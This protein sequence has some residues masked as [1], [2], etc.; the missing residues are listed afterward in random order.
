VNIL[1]RLFGLAAGLALLAA[2][3][4]TVSVASASESQPVSGVWQLTS[5]ISSSAQPVGPNCIV[6][7]VD[8][9]GFQGDLV[10]SSTNHT[11]I[12]HLGLCDQPA[13]ETFLT[14]GTFQGTVDG[15]AGTFDFQLHGT[16]DAQGNIQGPLVVLSGTDGLAN[17]HGQISLTG[18]LVSLS[19][20]YSGDIHFESSDGVASSI[21]L[22]DDVGQQS[23]TDPGVDPDLKATPILF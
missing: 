12:V 13:A 21:V 17:L 22:V 18:S 10:G 1:K 9:V 6:E 5:I 15:V 11:R 16:A 23:P 2:M 20:T 8:T 3:V 4:I 7:L 19:G 14:T